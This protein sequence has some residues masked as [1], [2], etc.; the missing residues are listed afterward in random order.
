MTKTA[1]KSVSQYMGLDC[2]RADLSDICESSIDIPLFRL[3]SVHHAEE[4]W[5]KEQRGYRGKEQSTNDSSP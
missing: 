2:D 4:R 3:T 1:I 5:N